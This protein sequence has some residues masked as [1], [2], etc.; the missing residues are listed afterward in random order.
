[1]GKIHNPSNLLINSK[2]HQWKYNFY[3]QCEDNREHKEKDWV[4]NIQMAR[5]TQEDDWVQHAETH[6]SQTVGSDF[7][8]DREH[9]ARFGEKTVYTDAGW[10]E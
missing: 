8:N 9:H 1:M 3:F 6:E 2:K 10:E 5:A 7:R 4:H